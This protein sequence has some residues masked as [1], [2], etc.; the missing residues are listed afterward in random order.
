MSQELVSY[1]V[2]GSSKHLA[3]KKE[4]KTDSYEEFLK[5]NFENIDSFIKDLDIKIAE[6][7]GEIIVLLPPSSIPNKQTRLK[8]KK[9]ASMP[10]PSWGWFKFNK[11]R[12]N[13][14]QDFKKMSSCL[15]ET[16][17]IFFCSLSSY[18]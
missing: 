12:K 2:L 14:G 4:I 18:L 10:F 13:I 1:I 5:L 3:N 16:S 8:L 15:I 11:F 17:A 9:L 7:N 6:S